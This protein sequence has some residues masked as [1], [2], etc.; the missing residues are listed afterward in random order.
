MR[1]MAGGRIYAEKPKEATPASSALAPPRSAVAP[2][3]G[4]GPRDRQPDAPAWGASAPERGRATSVP[5]WRAFDD[6]QRLDI[7][8]PE[9]DARALPLQAKLAVGAVDDPLEQEADRVADRVMRMPASVA[10]AP[11]STAAGEALQRKCAGCE[12]EEKVHRKGEGLPLGAPA[13]PPIVHSVLH[14]PGQPLDASVRALME[15]RFGAD[16]SRVRIHSDPSADAAARSI[17]AYAFTRGNDIVFRG[18]KFHPETHAGRQLL[19]HELT[20]VVQQGAAPHLQRQPAAEGGG[21]EAAGMEF[22]AGMVGDVIQRWPGD[23][24]TPPGDCGWANYLGLRGSVETAKAVVSML[25]ACS[26]GDNCSTLALKIAAIT[27]EIAARVALDSTCF[28]GGDTGHRQQ[29]H[30]KINMLNRC[31]RFFSDSKCPPELVA[32]MAVVVERAREV[33]AEAALVVAIALVAALVAAII[34]LVDVIA[35]LLAAAA[36]SAALIEAAAGLLALLP[37]LQEAFD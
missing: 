17:D 12:D 18:D 34:A 23:G 24:M 2:E 27:A 14:S 22:H 31:Y 30:D 35:A 20:H 28:K 16:F 11:T 4:W 15:P 8:R 5:A 19:A 37:G 26:V 7:W 25:G 9:G 36:E 33:I 6:R 3:R 1:R 10:S 29:V 13:A 21:R 32:A